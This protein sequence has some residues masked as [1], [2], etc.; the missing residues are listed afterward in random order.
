[1]GKEKTR[2]QQKKHEPLPIWS[3]DKNVVPDT[4]VEQGE[5]VKRYLTARKE[6]YWKIPKLLFFCCLIGANSP[7]PPLANRVQEGRHT[8][9]R[10]RAWGDPIPTKGQTLWYSM[11]IYYKLLY[12]FLWRY[13]E[14]HTWKKSRNSVKFR[15]ISRNYTSRNSP[16]LQ[17][18][19]R[20][21]R[22]RRK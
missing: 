22:N 19:P 20:G 10:G 16:E 6:Q 12:V 1:M 3:H 5:Q 13:T 14:F 8:R 4:S 18:I 2:R 11:Y 15:G 7:P 17:L 21:I 9:L